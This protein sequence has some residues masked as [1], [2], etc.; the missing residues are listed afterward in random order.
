M[1]LMFKFTQRILRQCDSVCYVGLCHFREHCTA[2][3]EA[4]N[5]IIDAFSPIQCNAVPDIKILFESL[6]CFL[7]TQEQVSR[8]RPGF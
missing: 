7:V 2:D 5:K 1:K 3:E 4:D 6:S 8:S